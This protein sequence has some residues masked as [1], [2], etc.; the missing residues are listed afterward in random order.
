MKQ[1]S[2]ILTIFLA[3]SFAQ[4]TFAQKTFRLDF[5]KDY[6]F[7]GDTIWLVNTKKKDRVNS[8]SVAILGYESVGKININGRDIE[9]KLVKSHLPDKNF[10]VGRGGYQIWKGKNIKV[11]LDYIY[12]WLC[13]P[14]DD[15][16]E[17]YHFKGFLAIDFNGKK[18]HIKINGSGGS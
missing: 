17:V 5:V 14:M 2:I 15:N 3:I 11:R 18:R 4:S 13:P 12:T 8:K 9:L 6:D 16:C 7:S 1:F 10:K